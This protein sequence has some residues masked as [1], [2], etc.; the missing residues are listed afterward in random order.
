MDP[1]SRLHQFQPR[2]FTSPHHFAG[3]GLRE[4]TCTFLFS[5]REQ[6]GNL[7][8]STLLKARFVEC[9]GPPPPSAPP[10]FVFADSCSPNGRG[11]YNVFVEIQLHL[12]PQVPPPSI[13]I[14]NWGHSS[15][16]LR[17]GLGGGQMHKRTTPKIFRRAKELHR[18][19]SPAEAQLWKHLRAHQMGDIHFRN[20]TCPERKCLADLISWLCLWHQNNCV[21]TSP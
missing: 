5:R 6:I 9:V 11:E 1:W 16:M 4:A 3:H 12:K 2:N 8:W 10:P 20:H 13:V 21:H 17:E 15:S 14:S 18:N 19:M 7:W